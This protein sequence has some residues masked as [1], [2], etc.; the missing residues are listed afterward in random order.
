MAVSGA[1][2]R[3]DWRTAGAGALLTLA[4][5]LPP[6]LAVRLLKGGDSAGK[7]SNLWVVTVLAIFAGFALGG[8]LA[9]RRQPRMALEHAAASSALAFF[10]LAAYSVVRHLLTGDGLSVALLVQLVLLGTVTVSIGVL[11]GY[12]ATRRVKEGAS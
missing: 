6:A 4:I 10:G 3:V 8:H 12:V 5:A 2:R 11:G 1:G 7:E 9:G